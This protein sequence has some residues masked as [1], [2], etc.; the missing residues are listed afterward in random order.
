MNAKVLMSVNRLPITQRVCSG[1]SNSNDMS[2]ICL[3]NTNLYTQ[4]VMKIMFFNTLLITQR[5]SLYIF[6]ISFV[7]VN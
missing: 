4:R 3:I 7:R 1:Y 6:T 2:E 5:V